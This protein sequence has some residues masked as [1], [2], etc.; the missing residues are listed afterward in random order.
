[1][2]RPRNACETC[3][4]SRYVRQ[5]EGLALLICINPGEWKVVDRQDRCR[6]YVRAGRPVG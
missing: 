2:G 1:M 5:D 3:L 4:H 6:K